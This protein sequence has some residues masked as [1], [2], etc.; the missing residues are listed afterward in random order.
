MQIKVCRIE[1]GPAK[2]EIINPATGETLSCTEVNAGQELTMTLPNAHEPSDIEV[3]EVVGSEEAAAA[4][5]GSGDG[6]GEG[7]GATA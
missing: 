2:V 3:G 6:S 4:G 5:E 7:E 1:D